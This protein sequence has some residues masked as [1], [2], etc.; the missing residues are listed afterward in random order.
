MIEII[1]QMYN[2]SSL[3]K[4]PIDVL[5]M[6]DSANELCRR[7]GGALVSRQIIATIIVITDTLRRYDKESK[8]YVG[9]R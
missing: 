3:D 1:K 9:N 6:L 2:V 5:D 7:A 8:Y 4:V